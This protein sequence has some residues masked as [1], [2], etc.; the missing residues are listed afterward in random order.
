MPP[1]ERKGEDAAERQPGHTRSFES[2]RLEEA[3]EAVG[4]AIEAEPLGRVG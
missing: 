3:G 4:V 2:Q 1:M